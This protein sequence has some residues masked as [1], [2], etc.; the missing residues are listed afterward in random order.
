MVKN[1]VMSNGQKGKILRKSV[2]D[3]GE[4][5]GVKLEVICKVQG[6]FEIK[7]EVVCRGQ[8][9]HFGNKIV[10]IRDVLW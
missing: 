3:R 1:E 4:V 6:I 7:S 8:N 10:V 9:E 2:V 5:F